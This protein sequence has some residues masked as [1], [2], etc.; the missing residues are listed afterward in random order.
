[1]WLLFLPSSFPPF[2]FPSR[3]FDTA[4]TAQHK[5]N[6]TSSTRRAEVPRRIAY[7]YIHLIFLDRVITKSLESTGTSEVRNL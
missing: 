1:M 6:V 5:A 7:I 2:L 4:C 3:S